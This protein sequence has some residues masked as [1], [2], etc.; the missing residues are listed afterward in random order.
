MVERGG[1]ATMN[2]KEIRVSARDQLKDAV[3]S[4]GFA[5]S[6]ATIAAGLP[7]RCCNSRYE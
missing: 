7:T 3:L 2:G 1:P 5:K 6:N 4:I